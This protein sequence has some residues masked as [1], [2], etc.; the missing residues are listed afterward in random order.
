MPGIR[1]YDMYARGLFMQLPCSLLDRS[2]MCCFP[3]PSLLRAFGPRT[4]SRSLGRLA[5]RR[6]QYP[7]QSLGPKQCSCILSGEAGRA[8]FCQASGSSPLRPLRIMSVPTPNPDSKNPVSKMFPMGWV[9]FFVSGPRVQ[10]KSCS[11]VDSEKQ[12]SWT[13]DWG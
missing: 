7:D 5:S 11:R 1:T 8:P 4:F 13:P 6:R 10:F 12:L 2:P 9:A 3:W